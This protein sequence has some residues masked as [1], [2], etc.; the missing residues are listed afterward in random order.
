ME[1]ARKN[2]LM[3][4]AAA[5]YDAMRIIRK[6]HPEMDIRNMETVLREINKDVEQA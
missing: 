3:L 5:I 4:D 6:R 1:T 2:E